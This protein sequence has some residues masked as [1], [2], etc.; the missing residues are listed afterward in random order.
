MLVV[1]KYPLVR[2]KRIFENN[3]KMVLMGDSL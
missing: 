3:I 1:G 2:P